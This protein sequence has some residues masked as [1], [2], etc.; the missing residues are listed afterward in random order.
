[1]ID[2]QAEHKEPTEPLGVAESPDQESSAPGESDTSTRRWGWYEVAFLAII[3]GALGLRLFELSERPMHYDEAIHLHYGWRLANSAG[4]LLGWP[5]IFGTD[6]VHSAWMHGPFQ[7]E[8]TAVIFTVLGDSDFTARLGYALFGTALVAL[9]YFLRDHIG[10]HGA[11]DSRSDA[12]AC[13]R[14]CCISADSVVTT[15]S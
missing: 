3:I 9:P 6:Y 5:W 7:I 15:S 11:L 12:G 4:S 2:S 14:P 13:L 1:M 10:R 8:M